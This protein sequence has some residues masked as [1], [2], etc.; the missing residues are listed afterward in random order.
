MSTAGLAIVTTGV[1][2]LGAPAISAYFQRLRDEDGAAQARHSKDL[3]ELRRL[4]DEA[5]AVLHRWTQQ[6]IGLEQWMQRSTF[7]LPNAKHAPRMELEDRALI[8]TLEARLVIRRGRND[9][10]V[11]KL[12]AYLRLVDKAL[13]EIDARWTGTDPF[14]YDDEELAARAIDYRRAFDA[15]VDTSKEIVGP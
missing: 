2:G 5:A 15:F 8:S 12:Q 9:G 11:T 3:D 1:V 13:A 14:D 10:L 7:G 6:L 4:L